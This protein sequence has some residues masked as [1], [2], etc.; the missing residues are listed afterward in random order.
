MAA[1]RLE[2]WLKAAGDNAA[3]D[4]TV[5]FQ[6]A[7]ARCALYS[8]GGRRADETDLDPLYR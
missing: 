1:Q 8:S 3:Q 4:S 5:N 2:K 7:D 6:A